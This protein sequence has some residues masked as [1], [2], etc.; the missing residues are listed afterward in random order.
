MRYVPN[1]P[2]SA[3]RVPD[4]WLVAEPTTTFGRGEIY[5]ADPSGIIYQTKDAARDNSILLKQSVPPSRV[6]PADSTMLT[7]ADSPVPR[8]LENRRCLAEQLGSGTG[9]P[10]K[11]LLG[12][13]CLFLL[14]SRGGVLTTSVGPF[15]SY[16]VA[17]DA[18]RNV[19]D[20]TIVAFSISARPR[21]YGVD[22]LRSYL[23][24]EAGVVHWTSE[25]REATLRDHEVSPCES[26]SGEFCPY[27]GSLETLKGH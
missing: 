20:S 5:Y 11:Q 14:N 17:F 18:R 3:G 6:P 10:L 26:G 19:Y 13:R 12:N 25:D 21:T 15:G 9:R 22:G 23:I 2:D 4:Y 1:A 7:I 8:L 24:D 16:R 27:L